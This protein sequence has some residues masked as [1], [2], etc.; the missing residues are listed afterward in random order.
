MYILPLDYGDRVNEREFVRQV[1]RRY[2]KDTLVGCVLLV[3]NH[4]YRLQSFL[5][6]NFWQKGDDFEQWLA[7][8][9]PKRRRDFRF[10]F[11]ELADAISVRGFNIATFTDEHLVDAVMSGESNEIYFFPDRAQVDAV[12]GDPVV[13]TTFS[14]FLS[15]SSRDKPFVDRVFEALHSSGIRAWYD[16]YQIAP[17]DSITDKINAGLETS[18]LGLIFLS[19]HFLDPKSGW[20]MNEANFFFQRRMHDASKRFIVANLGLEV[21]ELPAMLRDYKFIDLSSPGGI[22][23]V[24][25]AIT[26][27]KAA[28]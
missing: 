15:H 26:R 2:D 25:D 13:S 14:V 20:P 19:R 10:L 3:N 17:G 24:V 7:R 1:L 11:G 9:H 6:L 12:F 28:V 4:P 16:R 5:G 8:E 18:S 22:Q 21:E 23:E 27:A